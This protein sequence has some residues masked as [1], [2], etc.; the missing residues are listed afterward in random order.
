MN[1]R[2]LIVRTL[3][4]TCILFAIGVA[5]ALA[6]HG[7]IV[8][9][10]TSEV[11]G[12]SLPG[13]TVVVKGTSVGSATDLEG[14][15]V[16]SRVPAGTVTLVIGYLSFA[17]QEHEVVIEPG[18]TIN[19]DAALAPMVIQGEEVLVTAQALGQA[20]AINQQL[21][22]NTIV[23]VVSAERIQELPDANAAESIGRL[24]GVS[25]ER[26][27]GEGQKIVVRGLAPQYNLVTINGVAAPATDPENRSIDLSMISPE[28]LGAIEVMKA[29]TPDK[30]ADA[31]GGSVNLSIGEAP[32]GLRS[33][34]SFQSGYASQADEFG[35]YK[36]GALVSNRFFSNRLGAMLT[37]SVERAN[38]ASDQLSVDYD[39]L[40]NPPPGRTFVTPRIVNQ[41]HIDN[42]DTRMRYGSSL[43]LD[44]RI[45]GGMI[46]SSNFVSLLDRNRI[47]RR[48]TYSLNSNNVYYEL[49]DTDFTTG[50]FTTQ[51][52][53]EHRILGTEA[54]WGAAW[55]ASRNEQPFNTRLRFREQGAF[56]ARIDSLG[57]DMLV[58][59]AKH[60]LESTYLYEGRLE[61]N[62]TTESEYSAFGDLRIPVRTGTHVN[63]WVQFGGKLRGKRRSHDNE[64]MAGRFDSGAWAERFVAEHE[65]FHVLPSNGWLAM[66]DFLDTNY[67]EGDYLN[68]RFE[69]VEIGYIIDHSKLKR[70]YSYFENRYEPRYDTFLDNYEAREDVA[71]AYFMTELRFGQRVMFL[72]GFRYEHSHIWYRGFS[73]SEPDE[74]ATPEQ[75]DLN[76]RDTT[77][78]ANI[79]HFLPMVHLRIHPTDWFDIRLAY[80]NTLSRPNYQDLTPRR[81]INHTNGAVKY[82]NIAL[83]PARAQNYD[84]FLSFYG[85]RLGLLTVGG[86]FKEIRDFSYVREAVILAG[87]A[88]SPDSLGLPATTRGYTITTPFNNTF[89]ATIKGVEIGWQTHFRY[90][91][92][93]FDGIVL[94]ANYAYMDSD[95]RY[96][97]TEV[98]RTTS[99]LVLVDTSYANAF[100]RQ[101]KHIANV[102]FGYDLRGFSGRISFNYQGNVLIQPGRRNEEAAGEDAFYRW[103]LMLSQRIAHGLS[104]FFNMNNITNQPDE[105]LNLLT[106]YPTQLEY[107]GYTANLGVRYSYWGAPQV[108]TRSLQIHE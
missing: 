94:N 25:L 103:D 82:G 107:Y 72:P 57:P 88:L 48:R 3:A 39:A 42:L 53:G 32:A 11:T 85:N 102:S 30:D 15:Y 31:L 35:V 5:D 26:S 40:G 104:V 7:T 67:D 63:G 75:V 93:P 9:R 2:R 84:V 68:G 97:R 49:R 105:S 91:P 18:Q 10:V 81:T 55:Q 34:L 69:N 1:E 86:F 54:K 65:G 80:T 98:R 58:T 22:S 44:L 24:P 66:A 41:G 89:D 17:S 77:D 13:A 87:T 33:N 4:L 12:E 64:A 19:V 108:K 8:G 50:M 71:A 61:S 29:L 95:T 73:G 100:V 96:P 21:A 52:Q 36:G 62:T 90:L 106:G 6:Q 70:F 83:R 16:I 14:D 101:P 38:R 56:S 37:G 45:P 27:G 46:K 51:L 20:A 59:G 60:L 92:A 23:D 78:T 43:I 76:I 47:Q 28:M 79:G 74:D 99:G